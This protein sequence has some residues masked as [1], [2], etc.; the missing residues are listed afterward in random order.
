M[1][2]SEPDP[3]SAFFLTSSRVTTH[4]P[5]WP[6]LTSHP[7]DPVSLARRSRGSRDAA[8]ALAIRRLPASLLPLSSDPISQERPRIPREVDLGLHGATADGAKASWLG[9]PELGDWPW[10]DAGGGRQHADLLLLSLG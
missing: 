2:A 4:D 5:I 7:P 3:S 6:S 10:R 9:S 8:L 1:L